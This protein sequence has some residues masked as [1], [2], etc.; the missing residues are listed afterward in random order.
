MKIDVEEALEC[1]LNFT[2][3]TEHKR[4]GDEEE[5]KAMASDEQEREK[6]EKKEAK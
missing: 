5:K 2:S 1:I 6:E 3:R 4:L